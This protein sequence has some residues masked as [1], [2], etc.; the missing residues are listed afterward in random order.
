MNIYYHSYFFMSV[1]SLK[2]YIEVERRNCRAGLGFD[3][4]KSENGV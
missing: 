3:R 4:L 2:L 1:K